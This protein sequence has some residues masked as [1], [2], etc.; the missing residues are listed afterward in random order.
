MM[1][2]STLPNYRTILQPDATEPPAVPPA[3]PAAGGK[4]GVLDEPTFR[5]IEVEELFAALDHATTQIGRAVIYRSLS[6]PLTTRQ[7]IAAKQD[8]LR[9]LDRNGELR[10]G[11][12]RLLEEARTREGD[13]YALLFGRFLGLISSPAHPLEFEGYGYTQY[14]RGTAFTLRLIEAVERL[15]TPESPYLRQ[16]FEEIRR[17]AQSRAYALMR[18]PVYRS[19][20]AL[21]TAEEKQWYVPA[22]KFRPSLFKPGGLLL[23]GLLIFSILQFV[24]LVLDLAA[25]IA[26]VF[27]LF[28][29][30]ISFL[31]FPIVGGFDR[32]GCIYPLREIFKKSPDVASVL[33]RLGQLDELVSFLRYRAAVPHPVC[34][35]DLL[36]RGRH[37]LIV[38]G[39][40]NPVLGR[41]NADYV[42]NDIALDEERLTFIT[43]PNSGGKTAFCKTLA[44]TQLMAQI[45]CYVPAER[46]ALSVADRIFYQVPETSHLTDGEGRFGTELKRTKA[47]FLASTPRS[48]VIMDELSEGTTNEE[49][50]EISISVLD[51]FREKGNTTVLI[52]HNHEL[53]DQYQNRDVG[54]A[55]QVEFQDERPTYRLIEG[56]SRVSHADR[57][58][59]KIG[60]S[61]EDIAQYLR[62]KK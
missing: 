37:T 41:T 31:Y 18:G 12:E 47:I 45:G 27:W 5:V 57:I 11:L 46:A 21:L 61:K 34:L 15:P 56:I 50:L 38:T 40:R 58:A 17:F 1:S 19:E 32:D 20:K 35:P 8:A 42:A 2:I 7:D 4:S 62:G 59:R 26:P 3:E 60:F 52:T 29:L 24:P 53:V 55:R 49:K 44:Q 22:I 25:S 36:D 51:G 13:F 28:V 39:V 33:D 10:V 6:S 14:L 43:G 48:L 16:L 9:E 30:P 54:L 23:A